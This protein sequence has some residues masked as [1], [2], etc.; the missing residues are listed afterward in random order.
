MQRN[1]S[2]LESL[3]SLSDDERRQALD[4]L[5][6]QDAAALLY[7][8]S[9]YAR[10]NQLPPEGDWLIWLILA[11]RGF[12][13]TRTGA[14]WIKQEAQ[15][16]GRIALVGPTAADVR[17]IMIEGESGI[18]A[19]S[20]P[21]FRPD[22]EPSKR[23]LTWPNGALATAYSGDEPDRLRGPQHARAWVDEWTAFKYPAEAR[24]NL[25]FGLRLGA[26]PR[27]LF[28]QTPKPIAPLKEMLTGPD[29][30][31]VRG[32]T[33]DNEANLPRSFFRQIIG[34]YDGTRLGRQEIYAEVLEDVEG[35]LWHQ[36]WIDAGRVRMAPQLQRVVVAVD[37]AGEHKPHNDETGVTVAGLGIDGEWYVLESQGYRLSPL[38]WAK[39]VWAQFDRYQADKVIA[40]TNNGGEMVEATLHQERRNGP[41]KQIKASRGKVVRAEPVATLYEQGK[42]HHAGTFAALEE[43]MCAFPVANEHDDLVDSLVYAITEL[44]L[45]VEP[46]DVGA[47]PEE[48]PWERSGWRRRMAAAGG[49]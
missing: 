16:V 41:V 43:Q 20:A 33:Y 9:L 35:A 3:I 47:E 13:K 7:D 32:S 21:W 30:V 28:T 48:Q 44:G 23:R 38:G 29:V 24:D 45:G 2:L 42:V 1:G 22:Y 19:V 27:A 11:G 14:E 39:Q 46:V 4:T 34:A 25:L 12:G 37:P 49:G 15:H 17:D 6:D 36:A 5:S 18:M 10:D 8:W 40:E 31:V 26:K